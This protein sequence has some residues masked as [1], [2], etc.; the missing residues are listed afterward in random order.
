MS[1]DT[2]PA[3]DYEPCGDCG[4][5]HAYEQAEALKWHTA[6]EKGDQMK[7]VIEILEELEGAS[8]S[9]AKKEILNAAHDNE[10]LKRVF[11]AAGDPYTVYYVNKFAMPAACKA[12][13]GHGGP[14]DDTVIVAFLGLLD[15]LSSRELT[16]NAAKDA[17]TET[18]KGA[19][20]IQQKWCQRILLKNLRCGV[21]ESTVN[22]VWPGTLK[23][24]AVA[25]ATTVK[26]QFVEGKGIEVLDEVT[27]PVR[28]EPKLDGL[29][30]I[31][32]KQDGIVTLYTR[33]GTVLESMVRIKAALEAA[34]YDN[35][36]LD[37]EG[38]AA[39][40]SQSSSIMMSGR[41]SDKDRKKDDSDL[42]YN[43]FDA[44]MLK[45]WLTQ[46]GVMGY[47]NRV[48]IVAQVVERV[49]SP[50][51]CRVPHVLA[52]DEKQLLEFFQKC[53]DEGY[54]GVM[55]KTLGA[56]YVWKR[57][58]NIRKLKPCV[59]YEG[60]VVG[61]YEGR[62]GTK[63]EGLF[64][65]FE[66]LL[67]NGVVTRLGGGFSDVLKAS[68]QLDGPD[69]YVGRIAEIEAQPDPM[70]PDGLTAD[71][72]ARFPVFIRFRD[73]S[74]VDPKVMQAFALWQLSGK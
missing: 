3:T 32:V 69:T 9:N 60:V 58:D 16:G 15:K 34:D 23:S 14:D 22:K 43:V 28:V 61:H 1:D 8:G 70:T 35:I 45:E 29:R 44:I 59:T 21:Q 31:A 47:G 71:G 55:L 18:L 68:I 26:S 7:S 2:K 65:G 33:N 72:K 52:Q 20:T 48:G 56:P 4:F 64:G 30:C 51:V 40:W 73:E 19:L 6:R 36:V 12:M 46:E 13:R 25:L 49:N 74:D 37:G 5:D 67:P 17:V 42:V 10:L 62:R 54:E 53:M 57:S 50:C 38:M 63:R 11:V 41:G 66:L 24:F 39:D 27:Y